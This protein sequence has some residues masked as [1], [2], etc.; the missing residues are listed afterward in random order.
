MQLR[1]SVRAAIGALT[2]LVCFAVVSPSQFFGQAA[3][4]ATPPAAAPP[5]AA[6]QALPTA[7]TPATPPAPLTFPKPN[8][9]NFTAESPTVDTINQ[10]LK[11]SWGFDP[12]RAWQVEAILKTPVAGVTKVIVA[13]GEKG[14]GQPGGSLQFFVLPD[15]KHL[16]ADEVLPFGANPFEMAR[17][18]L[19]ER[20]TGPSRGAAS[21]DLLF[22]EFSDF[23]CPHCKDAQA[24]IDKLLADFP[25]AHFVY[26]NLP[27]VQVHTEAYKAASYSVCVAKLGGDEAFFKFANEVFA[28]QAALTPEA[29]DKTLKDAA[30]KVGV[31]ADKVTACST[32]PATKAAVDASLKLSADLGVNSTPTLYVNGRALPLGGPYDQLK[33]VIAFQMTLDGAAPGSH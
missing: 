14:T 17:K 16:I 26:E 20:A 3:T 29:S 19:L 31:D 23:Q 13:V 2:L 7:P 11:A 28:N 4:P 33:T 24:T 6:R 15:G 18:T 9:A 27:L 12:N 10:F 22:V 1:T 5:A 30:T 25:T 32:M 21:K 8:P